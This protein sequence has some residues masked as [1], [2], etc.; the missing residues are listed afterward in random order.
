MKSK[1][2]LILGCLT[3]TISIASPP[4]YAK[5]GSP[6][7]Y[8]D[9][10][11]DLTIA[12]KK[13]A[14]DDDADFLDVDVLK[15]D[16]TLLAHFDAM[17]ILNKDYS[18][19]F[20]RSGLA[21]K[22]ESGW[23]FAH[24]SGSEL[25][26]QG[27]FEHIAPLYAI[28][29]EDCHEY[30]YK[31]YQN[32]KITVVNELGEILIPAIPAEEV[33]LHSSLNILH[34]QSS[35]KNIITDLNGNVLAEDIFYVNTSYTEIGYVA[36]F[37]R[38]DNTELYFDGKKVHDPGASRIVVSGGNLFIRQN[39]YYTL[40]DV[41]LNQ[42]SSDKWDDVMYF[43]YQHTT[44][45]QQNGKWHFI[46]ANGKSASNRSYDYVEQ[47][48]ANFYLCSNENDPF[49]VILSSP[50]FEIANAVPIRNINFSEDGNILWAQ[51][52]S[53]WGHIS[54]QNPVF[55][56]SYT[57]IF[58]AYPDFY[59][60]YTIITKTLDGYY[61]ILLPD[62]NEALKDAKID[63]LVS[64][65]NLNDYTGYGQVII[66]KGDSSLLFD[67]NR[68]QQS[69]ALGFSANHFEFNQALMEYDEYLWI[70]VKSGKKGIMRV[71]DSLTELLPPV[72]DD[73]EIDYNL[74]DYGFI[75]LK[76]DGQIGLFDIYT[77]QVQSGFEPIYDDVFLYDDLIILEKDKLYG[78]AIR[79]ED[80]N[81]IIQE[82]VLLEK[83][84]YS[85]IEG[86]SGFYEA[87]IN[88]QL[89]WIYI[90]SPGNSVIIE[91]RYFPFK[92]NDINVYKTGDKYGIESFSRGIVIQADYDEIIPEVHQGLIYFFVRK[93][94]L[95]GSLDEYGDLLYPIEY[96]SKGEVPLD[97]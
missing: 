26:V 84:D 58:D 16:N 14:K 24:V 69:L 48:G 42:V 35:Q 94:D 63:R 67:V 29:N 60:E 92:K 80:V 12:A 83:P 95:W 47:M 51:S 70:S 25:V 62:G 4:S 55:D 6:Y 36:V 27:T 33:K 66:C 97:Y 96:N 30:A 76:K 75:V 31:A 1:L 37:S 8:T 65:K 41:F 13:Y 46:H 7:V 82:P 89:Q 21:L 53:G 79:Y 93:G 74:L 17:L 22:N 45:V 32:G 43:D 38:T 40:Y 19:A 3:G 5:K 49:E 56:F 54:A 78:Y 28:K 2:L 10:Y 87:R 86:H 39:D 44:A 15:S 9:A 71:N 77:Y 11:G 64:L 59:L 57:T 20:C 50:S 18:N 85:M 23:G 34:Y 91:E 61:T 88:G 72:Y 90:P 68:P 73:F 52:S 81:Y